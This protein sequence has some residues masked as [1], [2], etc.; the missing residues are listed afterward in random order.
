MELLARLEAVLLLLSGPLGMLDMGG[1]GGG[2]MRIPAIE[3][4]ITQLTAGSGI[5]GEPWIYNEWNPV[6]LDEGS[7][8][9]GKVD[10]SETVMIFLRFVILTLILPF[11][12]SGGGG[13]GPCWA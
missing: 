11:L 9:E 1:G 13:W 6:R 12:G 2:N 5:R 10:S 4:V 3:V 7:S 8:S